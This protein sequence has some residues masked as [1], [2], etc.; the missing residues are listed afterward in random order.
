MD[1]APAEMVTSDWRP[2]M[3]DLL[4]LAMGLGFFAV[5]IIYGLACDRL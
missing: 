3:L 2:R 5:F 4:L 1:A